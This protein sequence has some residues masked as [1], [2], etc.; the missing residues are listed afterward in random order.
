MKAMKI[1]AA[2]GAAALVA[3]CM[4]DEEPELTADAQSELAAELAGYV[5]DGEPVTCVRTPD[6]GGNRSVGEN[7]IIFDG[8]GGRK[9][10]NHLRN[11][12]PSLD[13]DRALSFRMPTTQLCRGEIVS[14]VDVQNNIDYGGCTLGEFTPYRRA[15]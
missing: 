5:Q 7:V 2:A 6:L 1:L 4:V 3:G 9:W 8:H 11:S 12:C 10:V 14:V 13:A 15:R